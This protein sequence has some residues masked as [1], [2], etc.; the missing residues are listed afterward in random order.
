MRDIGDIV[1]CVV[2]RGRGGIS[3]LPPPPYFRWIKAFAK[4]GPNGL[5]GVTTLNS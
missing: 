5:G 1:I 3:P 2:L 4:G